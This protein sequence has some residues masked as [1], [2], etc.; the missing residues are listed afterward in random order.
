MRGAD[1]W[2]MIHDANQ[3]NEAALEGNEYVVAKFKLEYVEGVN[4]DDEPIESNRF[5]Y[6]VF[7][8]EYSELHGGS[9]TH[10]SIVCPSPEFD[11]K[12]YGGASGEGLVV[13]EI[14][15]GSNDHYAV[16]A[17]LAWFVLSVE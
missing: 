13:F 5:D 16:F 6:T 10:E 11:C 7:S 15:E 3:F 4:P 12:L 2:D 9:R 8:P 1:A 14:A 17:D